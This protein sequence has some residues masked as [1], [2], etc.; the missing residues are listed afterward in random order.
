MKTLI[1]LL[2]GMT[3][4][5]RAFPQASDEKPTWHADWASAQRSARKQGKPIFAVMVCKH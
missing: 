2:I 5:T 3:C 4:G 1:V